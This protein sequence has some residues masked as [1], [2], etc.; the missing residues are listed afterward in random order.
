MLNVQ[1]SSSDKTGMGFVENGLSSVMT[2]TKF[3]P[4]EQPYLFIF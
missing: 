2:S 4:T 1:K 3:V